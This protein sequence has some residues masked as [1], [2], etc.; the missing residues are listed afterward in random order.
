MQYSRGS[1]LETRTY[2]LSS[3]YTFILFYCMCEFCNNPS[4]NSKN[5]DSR[6]PAFAGFFSVDAIDA[7]VRQAAA[8]NAASNDSD[9]DTDGT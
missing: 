5:S 3:A 9:D 6:Q 2:L 4:S 7:A 1:I 8:L